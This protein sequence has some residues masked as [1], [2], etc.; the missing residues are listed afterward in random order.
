MA[1]RA[2]QK[3]KRGWFVLGLG[4]LLFLSLVLPHVGLVGQPFGRSLF[5]TGFY[6][7]HAQAATF[8]A[9]VDQATLAFGFNVTYLGI[10]LHELGIMLAATT[11]WQLYPEE[12][13]RWLYR[14]M[15]IGGWALILSAPFI[16]TGGLL[17]GSSGAHA[18]VGVA[19]IPMLLSG[20][21]IT[22]AGRR[23]R[24]RVDHVMYDARPELM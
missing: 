20:V 18:S 24:D 22:V 17:M 5:L 9:P 21:A 14:A 10:G 2:R 13:N 6:L 15:V 16:I 11:F 12:L 7:L 19:W 4:I 8:G 3:R 1:E 23:A